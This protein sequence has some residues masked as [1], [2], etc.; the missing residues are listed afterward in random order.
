MNA[1]AT[2]VGDVLLE[3]GADG[4]LVATIDRERAMN[5]LGPAVL[6]GLH[7]A[8]ARADRDGHPVLVV[9]GSG[10]TLSTGADL[11]HLLPLREDPEAVRGYVAEIGAVN[12]AI[13]QARAVSVAVVDGY[14]VAGGCELMLAC[15]LSVVSERS[16]IGDR[17]LEY[18][19]LPGAGASV[20]LPRSLP[21]PL[22][23]RLMLTGEMLDGATAHRW[24]LVTHVA[25]H[26]EL[27]GILTQL[28]A[29][30]DRHSPT[31]LATMKQMYTE[32]TATPARAALDRE[33]EIFLGHVRTPDVAE[34]LAAFAEGRDPV[35]PDRNP[36]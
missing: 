21:A 27:E 14:A 22:A 5:S 32:A 26:T 13:E 15:D 30:L 25:P 7:E 10:G 6:V 11:H 1:A 29:R 24:G 9:R 19:L 4:A 31:A 8:A 2:R 35:F 3:V 20:R 17:H 36:H 33:L 34:G 12:L 28:R 18:G 16:Q 23:R